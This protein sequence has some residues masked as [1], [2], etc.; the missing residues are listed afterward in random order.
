MARYQELGPYKLQLNQRGIGISRDD[1][2]VTNM[3]G[4]G[5]ASG[6][7]TPMM[8]LFFTLDEAAGS[9]IIVPPVRL[10]PER[11]DL[12]SFHGALDDRMS[13][14]VDISIDASTGGLN[15]VCHL[16]STRDVATVRLGI[17]LELSG[18]ADPKWLIPG[19]FYNQNKAKGCDQKYPSYSEI[20]RDIGKFVSNHWNFRSDRAALPV[21]FCT[22]YTLMGFISTDD[23]VAISEEYPQG[24]GITSLGISGEEGSPVL[25]VSAPYIED[26]VKFSFC[27]ENKTEPEQTF[28]QLRQ[29]DPLVVRCKV[30]VIPIAEHG[31]TW[32]PVYRALH[33]ER[34]G[35]L[36]NA[37]RMESDE[38]ER[39][40]ID[41][42]MRWH[43]DRERM[44][45]HETCAFDRRFGR[46]GAHF[47]A[48]EMHVG[49]T[50]GVFPAFTLLWYG[51]SQ[52]SPECVYSA[53]AILN[54]I[55][56]ELAPCGT[57]W[58]L[59][60]VDAPE[61]GFGP[62]D[63]LAH[64]RTIAEAIFFLLR[65]FRLEL[66]NATLHPKWH[67]AIQS[68]LHFALKNQR[69]D[70]ALPSYWELE[71]GTVYDYSG[72]SGLVWVAA[73]AAYNHLDPTD[74]YL[75]AAVK[76][77]E[78]YLHYIDEDF[79]H[80]AHEDKPLVPTCDDCHF[81][82]IAYMILYELTGDIRWLEASQKAA[83]LALTFRMSYN[84][85]FSPFS[86]LGQNN[87]RTL[88]GDIGSVSQPTLT[89]RGLISY[90]ELKKLSALTG[91]LWY[92]QRAHEGRVFA[93][94][95]LARSDGEFNARLG[96]AIGEVFHTDWLQPKGMIST[97]GHVWTGA[98]IA[99]TEMVERH[100]KIPFAALEG[101]EEGIQQALRYAEGNLYDA[102]LIMPESAA[103]LR[104]RGR[105]VNKL[106]LEEFRR[107]NASGIVRRPVTTVGT[108]PNLT[109]FMESGSSEFNSRFGSQFG[110]ESE[111]DP[112]N[113]FARTP[114]ESDQKRPQSWNFAP[115][116]KT[117]TGR[118]SAASSQFEDSPVFGNTPSPYLQTPLPKKSGVF[119]RPSA[120]DPN[121]PLQQMPSANPARNHTPLS[122]DA[123]MKDDLR[124][125]ML[126]PLF[127]KDDLST[128]GKNPSAN[129][130]SSSTGTP[131]QGA[132]PG[133]FGLLPPMNDLSE[134]NPEL[135]PPPAHLMG[136]L[137]SNLMGDV[138]DGPVI[139][140]TGGP[141]L[142]LSDL[143]NRYP[144]NDVPPSRGFTIEPTGNTPLPK[145]PDDEDDQ[146]IKYKIF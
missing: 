68:N 33:A 50:S 82:T 35:S 88:G 112:R 127:S 11:A 41:G 111:F 144:D 23:R 105:D 100:M 10:H 131:K 120:T 91:D 78:F 87:F 140:P 75:D 61:A 124:A 2:K 63:G 108:N 83:D 7:F 13:L 40:A 48:D 110:A 126:Q 113:K 96:M 16:E 109:P 142:G 81:A 51:R 18:E 65:A 138:Q 54:R 129:R 133:G 17:H 3:L 62:K 89:A 76:A 72:S 119:K 39:L 118:E 69:D 77:G 67:W 37:L 58:P 107:Q 132:A 136:G 93:Q 102:Q 26:P 80:G 31:V 95:L 128:G 104:R 29:S 114:M 139:N 122:S 64:C 97:L 27:H 56:D 14:D 42:M 90:P 8:T 135:G 106:E 74:R 145:Y 66:Q 30:G 71:T 9:Q 79:L 130:Q 55:T 47:E 84:S 57:L 60:T 92:E 52:K 4:M 70:G 101:E 15:L 25:S 143:R 117:P 44:L 46:H 49:W 116:Q 85:S 115:P 121:S 5:G 146:E 141:D 6:G 53:Q 20:Q 103:S 19:L 1:L 21:V 59:F 86:M 32:H 94:Q 12:I 22:T 123:V 99:H 38:A 34:S 28:I 36:P 137:L 24:R 134:R 98:L 43:Y 125:Q 73:M 45:L